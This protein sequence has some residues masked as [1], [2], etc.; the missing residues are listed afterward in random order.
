MLSRGKILRSSFTVFFFFFL[1]FSASTSFAQSEEVREKYNKTLNE[2]EKLYFEKKYSEA[3]AVFQEALKLIPSE[4]HPQ[5]RINEINK[6]LGIQEDPMA[7]FNQ[8]VKDADALYE[9]QK[10][11]QALEAYKLAN[12]LNPGDE[13]TT[14]KILQLH[15][16]IREDAALH[17]EYN[18][19]IESANR[20]FD[21][22]EYQQAQDAFQQA[23]ELKPGESYPAGK[24]REIRDILEK[25]QTYEAAVERADELYINKKYTEARQAYA[26]AL[27]IKPNED[28]PQSLIKRIDDQFQQ[29][30]QDYE[31]AVAQGDQLFDADNLEQARKSYE[32][33]L[34]H[35]PGEAYPKSRISMINGMLEGEAEAN[36]AYNETIAGADKLFK[37]ENYIEAQMAYEKAVEIKPE[38]EYPAG[39][40]E[41]IAALLAEIAAEEEEYQRIISGADDLFIEEKY[42]EATAKYQEALEV[43]P[44]DPYPDSKISEIKDILAEIAA[45]EESYNQAITQADQFFE[46]ESFEE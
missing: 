7:N 27:E 36:A 13:Y 43:K 11:E 17:S 20:K 29:Q 39:Q 33:A 9:Q 34:E 18:R 10:Y 40:L 37:D 25:D 23:L 31:N 21:N 41:K 32:L 38:E 28:Y 22:G 14:E 4:K 8:A 19:L 26:E 1:L 3:K 5:S 16:M 44:N 24:I 46:D 12:D 6:M 2:A 30:E 45:T 15:T 42:D 35:K